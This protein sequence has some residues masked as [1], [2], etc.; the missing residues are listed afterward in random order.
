MTTDFDNSFYELPEHYA[1]L[2][3]ELL[4]HKVIKINDH[5]SGL[6]C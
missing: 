4:R 1:A 5:L 3:P 6:F 2:L